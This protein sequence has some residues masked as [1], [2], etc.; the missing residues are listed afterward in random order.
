MLA[1]PS[2]IIAADDLSLALV[3]QT[4]VKWPRFGQLEHSASLAGH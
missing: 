1:L 2:L 3:R 4:F